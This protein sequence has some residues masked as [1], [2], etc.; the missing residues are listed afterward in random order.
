MQD[1]FGRE[2][3]VGD[4]LFYAVRICNSAKCKIGKVIGFDNNTVKIVSTNSGKYGLFH[5]TTNSMIIPEELAIEKEPRFK[6][7]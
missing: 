2:I 1:Y 5:N 3:K 7:V 4:Y 6:D